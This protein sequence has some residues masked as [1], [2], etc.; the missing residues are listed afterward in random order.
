V[1][2]S[3][4][5]LVSGTAGNRSVLAL[6]YLDDGV[7]RFDLG[8]EATG[9]WFEG[10]EVSWG[11]HAREVDLVFDARTLLVRAHLDDRIVLATPFW[12]PEV[13][14]ISVGTDGFAPMTAPDFTGQLEVEPDETP[15]CDG[16]LERLSDG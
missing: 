13:T 11:D 12:R 6:T 7:V 14:E 8:V 5:L 3:E 15:I 1:G 16:I 10:Q 2:T 9:E 4:P